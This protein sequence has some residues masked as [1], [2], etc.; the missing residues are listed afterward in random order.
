MAYD[1]VYGNPAPEFDL[2]SFTS[3]SAGALKCYECG[4]SYG[5]HQGEV[6]VMSRREDEKGILTTVGASPEMDSSEP[7]PPVKVDPNP[8]GYVGRRQ[9]LEIDFWCEHCGPTK[10]LRIAQHKGTTYVSWV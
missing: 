4:E 6:R 1:D 8:S 9:H 5:L 2:D 10:T 3:L 7:L